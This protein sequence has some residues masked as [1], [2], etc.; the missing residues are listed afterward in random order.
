KKQAL[1]ERRFQKP[2][3]FLAAANIRPFF[4]FLQTFFALFLNFFLPTFN[5]SYYQ[6]V[7][8]YPNPI[9]LHKR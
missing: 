1:Y 6:S 7:R 2:L 5:P 4:P 8:H 9:P 3:P